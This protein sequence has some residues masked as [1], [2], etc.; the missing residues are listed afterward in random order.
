MTIKTRSLNGQLGPRWTSTALFCGMLY[1]EPCGDLE[2]GKISGADHG[3]ESYTRLCGDLQY[4]E[5]PGADH[6]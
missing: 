2:H 1:C 3:Y 4:G 5:I 6:G